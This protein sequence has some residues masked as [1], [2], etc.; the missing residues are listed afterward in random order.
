MEV[1]VAQLC[2]TF[3][4]LMEH[5]RL[6]CP[7]NSPGKNTGVVSHSLFQGSAWPRDLTQ[8][9]CIGGRF[10][11]IWATREAQF[12]PEHVEG[13]KKKKLQLKYLTE[14]EMETDHF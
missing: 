8:V 2:P 14:K 12:K 7:W 13:K 3:G 9:S 11:T 10:F 1:L 6:L 4:D 5:A